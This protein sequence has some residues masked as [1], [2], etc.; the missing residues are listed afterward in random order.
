LITE[1]SF[2]LRI[3]NIK[4]NYLKFKNAKAPFITS[5]KFFIITFQTLSLLF[6]SRNS[7]SSPLAFSEYLSFESSQISYSLV[8]KTFNRIAK[9]SADSIKFS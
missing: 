6:A 2:N 9:Q 8:N 1:D 4:Y 7:E 3:R 5:F